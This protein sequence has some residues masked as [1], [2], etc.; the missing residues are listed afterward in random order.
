MRED[1]T[2]VAHEQSTG[3]A[4]KDYTSYR[5]PA[6]RMLATWPFHHDEGPR[7]GEPITMW[8]LPTGE[9]HARFRR[10]GWETGL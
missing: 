1:Q 2:E 8:K 9:P 4:R 3:S 6:E 5:S 7:L 10:R